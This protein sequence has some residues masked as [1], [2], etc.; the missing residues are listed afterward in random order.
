MNKYIRANDVSLI[1]GSNSVFYH[2]P[3]RYIRKSF[4]PLSAA[5]V[6]FC[7]D[8]RTL[9]EILSN[10]TDCN[11]K[12]ITDLIYHEILIKA[13]NTNY[14]DSSY[15][16][17]NAH[18]VMLSD[19]ERMSK[20]QDAIYSTV[21]E[22]DVVIDAGSGTGILAILAAKAGAKKVF[23]IEST[24]I[25]KYIEK[26][27]EANN[28]QN[29]IEAIIGDFSEVITKE[30]ADI[31]VSEPLGSLVF[32]EK[33]FPSLY[34]CI[35]NN[36]KPEGIVIPNSYELFIG[37]LSTNTKIPI[38]PTVGKSINVDVTPLRDLYEKEAII[39]RNEV[40]G[41]IVEFKSLGK[42]PITYDFVKNEKCFNVKFEM[43]IK[44]LCAW[45]DVQLSKNVNLSTSPFSNKTHWGQVF[46]PI[47]INEKEPNCNLVFT[48]S[49]QHLGLLELK[50]KTDKS[51]YKIL[52]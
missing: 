18:R 24:K 49:N 37:N 41:N 46:L 28:V 27:A 44:G 22:G 33:I 51:N 3:Y 29:K 7:S 4:D 52:I 11:H 48:Y 26:L 15:S 14:A 16:S 34:K 20:Y 45:F 12:M 6:A 8:A 17:I 23:A 42:F 2:S 5:I 30:K 10:F 21:K 47:E 1:F 35:A 40:A 39:Y 19:L 31:I 43:P 50:V 36:M 9:S 13:N 32:R 38:F 25:G